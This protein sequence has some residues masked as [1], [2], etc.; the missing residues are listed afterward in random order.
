MIRSICLVVVGLH[1]VILQSEGKVLTS[2][3]DDYCT[4]K[5]DGDYPLREV[6]KYTHCANG[7]A[8]TVDCPK[9]SIFEPGQSKCVDISSQTPDTFCRNRT[10][11]DW[12]SPWNCHQLFKCLHGISYIVPCQLPILV[13]DPYKDQCVYPNEYTCKE[14]K[15]EIRSADNPCE[16]K[17]DG[18]Y[19]IADVFAYLQCA[20]HVASYVSCDNDDVFD[21][22]QKKCMSSSALSKD[23]FCKDRATGDHRDPWDCH[24]FAVCVHGVF[25]EK[26]CAEP[27]LVYDPY[28]GLCEYPY[29]FQ[30]KE[31]KSSKEDDECKDK[32][33]GNYAIADVFEYLTCAGGK[34]TYGKCDQGTIF[35]A[36]KGEC[37]KIIS[38]SIATFCAKR[39]DG[40]WGNPWNC[41]SYLSCKGGHATQK[42]CLINGFIY[43]PYLDVCVQAKDYPCKTAT[44]NRKFGSPIKIKQNDKLCDG[45]KDGKYPVP[46][47]FSYLQC[48]K[49]VGKIITC[50]KNMIFDHTQS[51]CVNGS[52]ISN[53]TFCKN[54]KDG[55]YQ[56]FWDCHGF[57]SCVH[58]MMYKQACPASLVYDPYFDLCEDPKS[59]HCNQLDS[60][61]VF[62]SQ[63]DDKKDGQYE[64][65][66]MFS[67]YECMDGKATNKTCPA[68]QIFNS[69]QQKCVDG[70]SLSKKIFCVDRA[71]GDYQDPWDCHSYISCVHG[72]LIERPCSIKT[73]VYNPYDSICEYKS[74]YQCHM[75]KATTEKSLI[76]HNVGI[77]DICTTLPDG[78]YATRD[79]FRVLQCSN[80]TSKYVDCPVGS[81]YIP[82]NGKTCTVS[83]NVKQE[84]FC[85]N[86]TDGNWQDPWDCHSYFTCHAGYVYPRKCS[87]FVVL[88]YDPD[89]DICE[90]PQQ[91]KCQQISEVTHYHKQTGNS[92]DKLIKFTPEAAEP[93]LA[94]PNGYY[95]ISDV[96]VIMLCHFHHHHYIPCPKAQIYVPGGKRCSPL[97]NFNKDNFCK[98]RS[99]G[100][101][102][103]PWNCHDYIT[104]H[105]GQFFDMPCSKLAVLVYNPYAN[106][107]DY[108]SQYPCVNI[109]QL[110]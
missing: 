90:Y 24:K 32:K 75:I 92:D 37:T 60:K 72:D 78:Y 51:K 110:E 33:D 48:T 69:K 87:P 95:A 73:L 56:N 68:N 49:E 58:G 27:D 85:V 4:G 55:N 45:K 71:T 66:D 31:I 70:S 29:I 10:I 59:F 30:C 79:V 101:W 7:K 9:N 93:C 53:K 28:N 89:N 94:L 22:K 18:D 14:I 6:F 35:D 77:K 63:C 52:T 15:S 104:C 38:E 99:D 2:T 8:S 106:L 98:G 82:G 50:G 40:D 105:A 91:R 12:Q 26:V 23:T 74:M 21:V 42:P 97:K 81:I 67:F 57:I 46:D 3:N 109:G 80:K 43:N 39:A 86:R 102:R 88:N 16:D 107:C 108:P 20:N 11:G 76:S 62:D 54:H 100:N 25:S 65:A 47:A 19:E 41:Y 13:F 44:V 36:T 84:N 103:N 96:G 64:L 34:A 5:P 83:K 61:N 1:L 17:G